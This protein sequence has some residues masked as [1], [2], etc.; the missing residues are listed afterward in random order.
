M[1]GCTPS[2]RQ[3]V[4][5]AAFDCAHCPGVQETA[6]HAI[7]ECPGPG[8]VHSQCGSCRQRAPALAKAAEACTME[9]RPS[10]GAWAA[11][12]QAAQRGHLLGSTDVS[13]LEV[14]Q[15]RRGD[16]TRALG[17]QL[18]VL[19]CATRARSG[20]PPE[21]LGHSPAQTPEMR[22]RPRPPAEDLSAGLAVAALKSPW[23]VTTVTVTVTNLCNWPS[24][25][26]YTTLT[27]SMNWNQ[28]TQ[29]Q[30]ILVPKLDECLT[31]CTG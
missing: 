18:V 10:Q 1:P 15:R 31:I 22:R 5:D 6:P 13:P 3:A 17:L 21:A 24:A 20:L 4:G 30:R 28:L 11:M 29:D 25:L 14:E 12:A 16:C 7:P 9:G 8:Q 23:G 27:N 19:A 26:D 2:V